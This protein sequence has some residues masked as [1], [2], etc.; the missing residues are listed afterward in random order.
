MFTFILLTKDNE[1]TLESFSTCM[2]LG[3]TKKNCSTPIESK[4][5]G[6]WKKISPLLSQGTYNVQYIH[7]QSAAI[8]KRKKT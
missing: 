7:S 2:R 3:Y 4:C 5:R 6:G 1:G 8:I